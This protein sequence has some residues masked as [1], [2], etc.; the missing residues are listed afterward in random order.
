MISPCTPQLLI[1]IHEPINLCRTL[2]SFA[3]MANVTNLCYFIQE[4]ILQPMKPPGGENLDYVEISVVLAFLPH[5]ILKYKNPMLLML[6]NDGLT[7]EEI[8]LSSMFQSWL[9]AVSRGW[10][11]MFPRHFWGLGCVDLFYLLILLFY[12][13]C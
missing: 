8:D 5:I 7:W 2:W 11:Y 12:S 10:K 3:Y 1:F 4:T 6:E 13:L 9:I